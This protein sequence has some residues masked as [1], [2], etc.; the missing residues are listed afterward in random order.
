M[1]ESCLR[2]K[3]L[4]CR[5]HVLLFFTWYLLMAK[6]CLSS[7]RIAAPGF[8]GDDHQN[9]L[10]YR[11]ISSRR[12]AAARIWAN[13]ISAQQ[14]SKVLIS[15]GWRC[16]LCWFEHVRLSLG[17]LVQI[18]DHK[19]Q[20]WSLLREVQ[21]SSPICSQ[22]DGFNKMFSIQKKHQDLQKKKHL[23]NL[24]RRTFNMV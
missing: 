8:V 23:K 2:K 1:L 14:H 3:M 24:F 15:Q 20:N 17:I 6:W 7:F 10:W 4:N 9:S 13:T 16:K 18:R 5:H 12:A 22:S 19:P 21:I 11:I